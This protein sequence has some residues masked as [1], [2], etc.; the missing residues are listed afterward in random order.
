MESMNAEITAMNLDAIHAHRL[1]FDVHGT[2]SVYLPHLRVMELGTAMD[3]TTI[4]TMIYLMK[5]GALQIELM[6][7]KYQH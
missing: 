2:T 1:S 5:Q 4:T 7:L 3:T 6:H